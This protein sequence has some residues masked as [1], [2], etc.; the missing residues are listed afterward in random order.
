[1]VLHVTGVHRRRELEQQLNSVTGAAAQA[2]MTGN[3]SYVADGDD[4]TAPSLHASVFD[5]AAKSAYDDA[6]K[7]LQVDS[8]VDEVWYESRLA[9]WWLLFT[10]TL[11]ACV[12]NICTCPQETP[13]HTCGCKCVCRCCVLGVCVT[14]AMLGVH[15]CV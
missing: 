4:N 1:M 14:L 6:M 2:S 10:R 13:V 11:C 5:F 12:C 9:D 15:V 3:T 8:V 7:D